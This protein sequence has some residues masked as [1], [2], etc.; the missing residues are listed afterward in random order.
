[1]KSPSKNSIKQKEATTTADRKVFADNLQT[2]LK[3]KGLT[4][5]DFAEQMS[6]SKD[7]VRRW[8]GAIAFPK[9][10]MMIKICNFFDHYD[11]YT[12]ITKRIAA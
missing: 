3:K 2:L 9:Y 7:R 12:L 8:T 1:M 10:E 11:I 5:D 6:E 4:T